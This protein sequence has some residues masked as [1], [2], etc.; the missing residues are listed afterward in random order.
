V[1][2]CKPG[3][4]SP[5]L[6]DALSMGPTAPPP[7]LINQQRYGPPPSY[8]ALRIPGLNAPIP[9]GAQWGFQPG[10]WGRPPVDEWGRG[11]YGDVFGHGK[12]Q[13]TIYQQN[14]AH[15]ERT[16]WGEMEEQEEESEEE[17]EE[18][19]EEV[20]EPQ[21]AATEPDEVE[22]DVEISDLE[23]E[24]LE[25]RKERRYAD[26][27][28]D[29][30]RRPD[31]DEGPK[32][33]Y[34]V[35]P[36]KA[37]QISGFMGSERVY[38]LSKVQAPVSAI[39]LSGNIK[40]RKADEVEVSLNPDVFTEDGLDADEVLK[41][42]ESKVGEKKGPKPAG[43]NEDLSDLMEEHAKKA[44]EKRKRAEERRKEGKKKDSFKF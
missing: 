41:A 35:I 21:Q 22:E 7:W 11:L 31:R 29:S 24:V 18:V 25:I 34:Q 38:D 14:A 9:A 5:E 42:Y 28:S 6:R 37:T 10:G 19:E 15:V 40:K 44:Q 32:Q 27:A 43:A 2:H 8:P 23:P 13:N 17:V 20:E 4:I 1:A 16:L 3:Q 36:D 39:P 12:T 26:C 30:Q 33:L